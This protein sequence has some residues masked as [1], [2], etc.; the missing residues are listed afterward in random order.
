MFVSMDKLCQLYLLAMKE[1]KAF[2]YV[3]SPVELGG[4]LLP[5]HLSRVLQW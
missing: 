4:T 5:R 1:W 3:E 2:L